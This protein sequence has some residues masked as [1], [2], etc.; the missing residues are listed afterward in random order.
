MATTKHKTVALPE[1][2]FRE[3]LEAA[4]EVREEAM[5]AEIPSL[6]GMVPGDAFNCPYASTEERYERALD[7][8]KFAL[9][10]AQGG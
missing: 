8:L 10:E 5:A 4:E 7:T 2:D 3:F 9:T 6:P 1:A